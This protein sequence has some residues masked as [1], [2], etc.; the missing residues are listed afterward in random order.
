MNIKINSL[1]V[2]VISFIKKVL[3]KISSFPR[4]KSLIQDSGSTGI[5]NAHKNILHN[6]TE[7]AVLQHFIAKDVRFNYK[8]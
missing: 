8:L 2:P 7:F 4:K 1:T 5:V 6:L 3:G